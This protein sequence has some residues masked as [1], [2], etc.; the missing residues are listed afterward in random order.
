MCALLC[1][2]TLLSAGCVYST[3]ELTF[4]RIDVDE[5]K[6]AKLIHRDTFS[7]VVW[8]FILPPVAV[9]SVKDKSADE[10]GDIEILADD[11]CVAI[12]LNPLD[13]YIL[14]YEL[15][16]PELGGDER[17][18]SDYNY[19]FLER[20]GSRSFYKAEY[21]YGYGGTVPKEFPEDGRAFFFKKC[22][23]TGE[24]EALLKIKKNG[25][26]LKI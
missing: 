7:H 19:F 13:P 3:R 4:V 21:F 26:I 1:S 11:I 16:N 10:A 17:T 25:N 23:K 9:I 18:L 14:G 12:A 15:D 5:N 6:K 20:G 24:E 8:L 2:S 22:L